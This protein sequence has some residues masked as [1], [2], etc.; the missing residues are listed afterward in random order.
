VAVHDV[1]RGSDVPVIS[2]TSGGFSAI[3]FACAAAPMP[4]PT[5]I[6]SRVRECPIARTDEIKD[7]DCLDTL[8]LSCRRRLT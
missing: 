4:A 6:R 3:F 5:Y 7:N 1:S 8:H 2:G